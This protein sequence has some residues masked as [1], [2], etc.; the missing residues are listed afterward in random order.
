MD[1]AP[2]IIT[3]GLG[4]NHSNMIIGWPFNLGFL[5]VEIGSP[6]LPPGS[7]LPGSPLPGSPLPGSPVVPPGSP[8]PGSPVIPPGSPLG[9]PVVPPTPPQGGGG[10]GIPL[11]PGDIGKLYQPVDEPWPTLQDYP[12]GTRFPVT[13]KMK[14]KD[15]IVERNYIVTK[16]RA[17]MIVKVMNFVKKIQ[18]T[19]KITIS[20]MKKR[21]AK[22][23]GVFNIRKK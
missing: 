18:E 9:S 15:H 23:M 2:G 1:V 19:A 3:F 5:Q 21:A 17:G 6:I 10:G 13:I 7:P 11:P 8:L 20:N 22:V 14:F 16:K 12:D 4:G